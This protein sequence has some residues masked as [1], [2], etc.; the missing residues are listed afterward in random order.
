MT[1]NPKRSIDLLCRAL[2]YVQFCVGGAAGARELVK[3]MRKHL[4]TDPKQKPAVVEQKHLATLTAA[5]A[6]LYSNLYS[7]K[8]EQDVEGLIDR[9]NDLYRELR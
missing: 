2:P 8:P 5:L 6:H 1:P 7:S 3:E 9:L 4:E